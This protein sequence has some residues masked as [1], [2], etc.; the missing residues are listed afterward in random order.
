MESRVLQG[1]LIRNQ[2]KLGLSRDEILARGREV[3]RIE[4]AALGLLGDTLGD[5]F[6]EACRV[7]LETPRQLVVTGMGK[8]GHIARKVAATFAATGT[9]AIFVHPGE[10]AHGD[11]GMLAE[12]DVLLVLSNSGNTS[13]LRAILS[14]ARAHR[15]PII[16]VASRKHSQVIKLADVA[17]LL[18][19]LPEACAVNIAPTTSTTLQLALGDALAMTVMDMRGISKSRLHMLHPGGHIGLALTPVGEI[20]RG[21]ED[22]PLVHS[23]AA[24]PETLSVMTSGCFGLAGVTNDEGVLVGVIT[25]G[26]LRRKFSALATATAGEVMTPN[27]KVIPIDTAAKDALAF[28]NS[29]QITAAFVVN[30]AGAAPGT[31]IRPLGIIHIHDLLRFELS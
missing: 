30:E 31:P 4:A 12:G 19:H 18:P 6:V 2:R 13:E 5:D 17:L 3:V 9:P 14:Y 16:G 1:E 7:I 11:L 21:L 10:A 28:L 8:S 27:P 25:D 29:N 23:C 24:M 15:I 26:D 20:M 22:M